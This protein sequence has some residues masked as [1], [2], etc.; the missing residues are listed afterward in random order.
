MKTLRACFLKACELR[1]VHLGRF[2]AK[3]L[4]RWQDMNQEDCQKE[5]LI[6]NFMFQKLHFAANRRP[7]T[8]Y[9]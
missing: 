2:K 7:P 1:I 9:I 5:A 6:S 8:W 3:A 4:R